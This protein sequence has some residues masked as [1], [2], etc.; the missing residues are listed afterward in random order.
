M[1]DLPVG[2]LVLELQ[3]RATMARVPIMGLGPP[4]SGPGLARQV[5]Y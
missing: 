5:L 1:T 4:N 3:A 2:S